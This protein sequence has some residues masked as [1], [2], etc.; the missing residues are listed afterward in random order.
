MWNYSNHGIVFVN[1][2]ESP[3]YF[4]QIEQQQ[5]KVC[6]LPISYLCLGGVEK[7]G[8]YDSSNNENG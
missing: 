6:Y 5:C 7:M 1:A 3:A 4:V 2:F 8:S